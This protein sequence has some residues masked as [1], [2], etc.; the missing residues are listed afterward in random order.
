MQSFESKFSS[1][2]KALLPIVLLFLSLGSLYSDG[3]DLLWRFTTGGKIRGNPA[4]TDDGIVYALSEDRHLYA[5]DETDGSLIWRCPL[6]ERVWESLSVGPDGSIYTVSK[7]GQIIAV[8]PFGSVIWR[9]DG[10]GI[11]AGN[12]VVAA[13]GS[14]YVGYS[15]GTLLSLS[16]TGKL[17]WTLILPKGISASPAIASEGTVYV[18]GL[19]NILYAVSG[20]GKLLWNAVLA[21]IPSSPALAGN[22]MI[23]VGTDYGSLVAL[24]PDGEIL[25]DTL[26]QSRFLSPVVSSNLV[27]STTERGTIA[28]YNFDGKKEWEAV[29]QYG[30]IVSIS[31]TAEGSVYAIFRS[32][33]V[34]IL[35]KNLGAVERSFETPGREGYFTLSQHGSL[36]CGKDDWMLYA[37]DAQPVA[38]LGWP[39]SGSDPFHSG[40]QSSAA[41][42]RKVGN[43]Y[44][45]NADYLYLRSMSD[46]LDISIKMVALNE[47][48]SRIM[49]GTIG[50]SAAYLLMILES[51]ASEGNART[52]RS[53]NR[54]I[55]D[56]PN[57]RSEA[58]LLL[59]EIGTY[60]TVAL[61]SNLLANERDPGAAAA[62]VKSLGLLR[63]D[64]K[65]KAI[66]AISQKVYEDKYR[67]RVPNSQLAVA[68]IEAIGSIY[69]YHGAIPHPSGF[70][71]L[72]SIYTGEYPKVIKQR[73][74]DVMRNKG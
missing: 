67:N 19:D 21:G 53:Q 54:I 38:S 50:S 61:L 26:S 18:P 46:S 45:D 4:V 7:N 5:I 62:M 60:Q 37:L 39:Q 15:S 11:P 66:Q 65:G 32:G 30:P 20:W 1:R 33:R 71:M 68:A 74:L 42:V 13:D 28:A 12:P 55:N 9:F 47:I 17:R 36:I 40:R 2:L 43:Y 63:S 73:A 58:S 23:F 6:Q 25:W 57:I 22:G 41:G 29:L 3:N 52:M 56:F 24:N 59:G 44:R 51:L 72:F 49:N 31:L 14:I 34:L 16:H 70:D 27:V 10:D 64:K 48:R 8:N 35:S 69:S